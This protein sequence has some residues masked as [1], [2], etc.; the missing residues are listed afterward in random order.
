MAKVRSEILTK[1]SEPQKTKSP[2][3]KV[4]IINDFIKQENNGVVVE[5]DTILV[6]DAISVNVDLIKEGI[7]IEK[8]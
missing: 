6:Q 1:S 8:S 5:R 2:I 7:P 3:S 4:S